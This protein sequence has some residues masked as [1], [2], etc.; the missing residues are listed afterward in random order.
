GADDGGG[1]YRPMVTFSRPVDRATLTSASFFATDAGGA[2][3]PST[4]VPLADA[5][6]AWLFFGQAMPGGSTVTLHVDGNAIKGVDGQPLDA[7]GDGTPGGLLTESFT[8]VGTAAV[9]G[10][11]I[12]GRV[13]DT[14]ADLHP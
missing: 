14:G 3:I 10:T 6:G 2:A 8:T 7:D 13:V 5:T 9:P 1:T 11:T 4:I 12:S